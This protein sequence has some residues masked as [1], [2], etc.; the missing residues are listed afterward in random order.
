MIF[1]AVT[2]YE[3][4]CQMIKEICYSCGSRSMNHRK[5]G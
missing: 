1:R 3:K 2:D 4:G 5:E